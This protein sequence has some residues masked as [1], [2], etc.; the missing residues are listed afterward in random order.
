MLPIVNQS[1]QGEKLA[2]F[3]QS[4]HAKHPMN[5][6]RL[7][8]ITDLHLMQGPI[9][10]FDGGVYAGDAQVRDLA[11]GAS[12]LI[13][14]AL[15]LDTEVVVTRTDLPKQL[16]SMHIT[17]G[18]VDV[19]Y[20]VARTSKYL[21]DSESKKQKQLIIEHPIDSQY[22]LQ[23]R[24]ALEETTRDLY[25][26]AI[27]VKPGATI[28]FDVRERKTLPE[29]TPLDGLDDVTI[30]SYQAE[31]AV[32]EAVKNILHQ[33]TARRHELTRVSASLLQ[34]SDQV[35]EVTSWQARVRQNMMALDKSSKLYQQYVEDL[36]AKETQLEQL[37]KESGELQQTKRRLDAELEQFVRQAQAQ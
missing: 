30:M 29:K 33:L 12:R 35:R 24:D 11:P 19:T 10:V 4:V 27:D 1:V 18:M 15:D 7:T 14:Y 21:V 28:L 37:S 26:F 34:I 20:H 2:I 25:R 31:K 13:S 23:S 16:A 17:N 32:S 5:G 6:L 8:N 9:T 36:A 3:N 22:E